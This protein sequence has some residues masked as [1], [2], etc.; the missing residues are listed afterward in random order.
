M[1]LA[2]IAKTAWNVYYLIRAKGAFLN[3]QRV[4]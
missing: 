2:A 1:G 4:I 3:L